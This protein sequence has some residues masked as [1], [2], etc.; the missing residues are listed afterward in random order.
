MIICRMYI[1]T[2]LHLIVPIH[3]YCISRHDSR[4]MLPGAC[5]RMRRRTNKSMQAP[6]LLAARGSCWVHTYV[7]RYIYNHAH[8]IIVCRHVVVILTCQDTVAT[9]KFE[10]CAM[11]SVTDL[12]KHNCRRSNGQSARTVHVSMFMHKSAK[13]ACGAV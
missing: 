12:R 11:S 5:V 7:Y 10:Y 3:I 9:S 1:G 6:K 4:L 2:Y 13:S 8:Q